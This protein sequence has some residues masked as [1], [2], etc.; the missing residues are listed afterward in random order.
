VLKRLKARLTIYGRV[1]LMGTFNHNEKHHPMRAF[2][3]ET[4]FD[5]CILLFIYI[6]SVKYDLR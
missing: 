3:P 4:H 6:Y 5:I 1:M 2:V